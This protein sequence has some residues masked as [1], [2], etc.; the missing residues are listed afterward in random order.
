VDGQVVMNRFAAPP[1]R[2]GP[3]IAR[4][5]QQGTCAMN[6]LAAPPSRSGPSIARSQ[7]G[8]MMGRAL[9]GVHPSPHSTTLGNKQRKE[10]R[11][12]QKVIKRHASK[13]LG[14]FQVIFDWTVLSS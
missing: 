5:Q 8:S 14:H 3:P 1:S 7:R 2:S 10:T 6:R 11:L 12:L 13:I 4:S 9:R